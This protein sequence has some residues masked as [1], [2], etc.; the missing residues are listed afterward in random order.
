M[1]ESPVLWCSECQTSIAQAEL[2]TKECETTFHYLNFHTSG[3]D[4]LIA[5]TRPELLAGCACIFVHPEDS[6]YKEYIGKKATV[7]LYDYEI[8]ILADEI[9]SMEKGTGAVMC[10]TFGDSV[11]VEW[12]QKYNL[13]YRQV[14]KPNGTVHESIDF[15]SGMTVKKARE[16]I[17]KLL[18]EKK[19]LVKQEV[20]NHIIA[21]HERCGNEVEFIPSK[22]WYI[23][24][25]TEKERY[26]K[27]ADEINWYPD[28]MKNRYKIWVENLKWDWCISRQRYFGVPFPVWYCENC[29][30]GPQTV[31]LEQIHFSVKMN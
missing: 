19:F 31:N 18:R 6:R 2:E 28:H 23:D 30:I 26:L 24:V 14:I 17:V 11:D 4:L 7:L 1:K 9:V 25:L 12:Y 27:I 29:N 15:I 3:G 20:I 5:T 16:H 8:P 22:Q 10:A 21:I 13:S